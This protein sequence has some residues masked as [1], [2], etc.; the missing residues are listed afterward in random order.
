VRHSEQPSTRSQRAA[1][2][3]ALL[4][5]WLQS[6]H[7]P[8]TPALPFRVVDVVERTACDVCGRPLQPAARCVQVASDAGVDAARLCLVCGRRAVLH[9][10]DERR[11]ESIAARR[12]AAD[13][14]VV[15]PATA[16]A[17]RARRGAR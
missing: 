10:A 16:A 6:R 14:S 7:E 12:L 4:E 8:A 5:R 13:A 17:A 9:W 15:E 1:E 2:R 3:A 11:R